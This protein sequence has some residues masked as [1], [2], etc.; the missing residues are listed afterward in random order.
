MITRER[1]EELIIYELQSGS[2][3]IYLDIGESNELLHLAR[4]GL[5]YKELKD[6]EGGEANVLHL[7]ELGKWAK[8]HG[9]EAMGEALFAQGSRRI[10]ACAGWDCSMCAFITNP[11]HYALAALPKEPSRTNEGELK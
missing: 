3:A 9:I 1:L 6:R 10:H 4:Q 7:I 5:E 11:I 2:E 8:E